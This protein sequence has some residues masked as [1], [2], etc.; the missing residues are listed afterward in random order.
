MDKN[1]LVLPIAIVIASIIVGISFM[2]IQESK[3]SAIKEQLLQQSIKDA[4]DDAFKN[5]LE[6]QALLPA[7]SNRWV[8][9]NGV[10]YSE[11]YK[12]CIVKYTTDGIPRESKLEDMADA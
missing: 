7:L 3:Q 9:V 10:Y 4:E 12:T 8:N 11:Y 5:K 6:C 2:S 1:K